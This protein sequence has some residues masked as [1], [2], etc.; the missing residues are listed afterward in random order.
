MGRIRHICLTNTRLQAHAS[1]CTQD[2]SFFDA[3]DDGRQWL[4]V[5]NEE[6]GLLQEAMG[7]NLGSFIHDIA[8]FLI[9]MVGVRLYLILF[10]CIQGQA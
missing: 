8:C 10:E 2:M 7:E 9:G 4:H 1:L 5:L 6:A 3:A